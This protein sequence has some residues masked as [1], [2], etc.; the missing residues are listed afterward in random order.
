MQ[1]LHHQG[2]QVC[3]CLE[4]TEP[5]DAAVVVLLA[6][7]VQVHGHGKL[8]GLVVA[9]AAAAVVAAVGGFEHRL[10]LAAL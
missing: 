10:L 9:A 2:Q 6:L 4:L 3:C 1:C 5:W 8:Q 7:W